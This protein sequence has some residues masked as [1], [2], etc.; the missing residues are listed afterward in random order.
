MK[1]KKL[2]VSN[3]L[4]LKTLSLE[5]PEQGVFVITGPNGSGKSSILEAMYFAL[6]GKTMRLPGDV[7]NTAIINR[8]AQHSSDR[9]ATAVVSFTF[10]QQG[11]E[12]L[13]RREL[14]R[15]P[16]KKD[17]VTHNAWFY[18]LNSEAGGVPETG[19][20]KVNKKVEDILGLTPEV[21]AATVFLGQGKITELVEA[22]P[23]KRRKI[24][25]SILETHHLSKMQELVR[26]DL[27]ELQTKVADQVERKEI[28]E[29]GPFPEDLEKE[30][31]GVEENM[32][33]IIEKVQVFEQAAREL[34]EL[35]RT[36]ADMEKTE[37]DI[38]ALREEMGKLE[39]K[40]ERDAKIRLAK[41]L[42]SKYAE[43]E[44][45]QAQLEQLAQ[46][47]D[48]LKREAADW[49]DK[50]KQ[51]AGKVKQIEEQLSNL[52]D[53]APL[54]KEIET[55][56]QRLDNLRGLEVSLQE[57]WNT[58]VQCRLASEEIVQLT[59]EKR[60]L[61][62]EVGKLERFLD[63]IASSETLIEEYFRT[64]QNLERV[65]QQKQEAH[66]DVLAA[67]ESLKALKER[68]F[69]LSKDYSNL[70]QDFLVSRLTEYLHIGDTCP[71]CGSEITQLKESTLPEDALI[72]F[73]KL[74]MERYHLEQQQ[75]TAKE[76]NAELEKEECELRAA[77]SACETRLYPKVLEKMEGM[78]SFDAFQTWT[79]A[80]REA[81]LERSQRLVQLQ[82]E[83]HIK[84]DRLK[85]TYCIILKRLCTNEEIRKALKHSDVEE[86]LA[87]VKQQ[88]AEMENRKK[89]LEDMIKQ[90]KQER[91]DLNVSLAKAH[92]E[93]EKAKEREVELK[94][95]LG[96]TY[97]IK[98]ELSGQMD[99]LLSQLR[100]ELATANLSYEDY[101]LYKSEQESGA[102]DELRTL[103]GSLSLLER[104]L[105]EQQKKYLSLLE[106]RAVPSDDVLPQLRQAKEE[107][108][109]LLGERGR[110]Q[111]S[112]ELALEKQAELKQVEAQ[113]AVLEKELS[114]LSR[115]SDDLKADHF[116]DFY[117][118]E[119]MNE[120]VSSASSLLWEMS[121]GQFNLTF[122]SDSF[123]FDVVFDDGLVSDISN[124]SGGER[125]LVALSLAFAISQHFAGSLES[126]FLDEGLAW[127]DKENNTKLAQYLQNM[128]DGSILVGIVTHSE[129]FAVNFQRRLYVNGGKAQWI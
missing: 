9:P 13:V 63:V 11:K 60:K 99:R 68:T 27:R 88:I 40:A 77:L 19:V 129:E 35:Q 83:L 116:P 51:F 50:V 104:R 65:S 78:S 64:K 8:N 123:R 41:E 61:Q 81:F 28:L 102:A 4:G 73:G 90:I 22:K 3:F 24:F 79:R 58:L 39:E 92:V 52:E 26:G 128:E 108:E 72:E 114:V 57:A 110:I 38:K 96:E 89:N 122:D 55:L 16:H 101:L 93:L 15:N 113:L 69:L 48:K 7:K 6:Y 20:V 49:S 2:E 82:Q 12:Y 120:I 36:K 75:R 119:M 33:Q 43:L 124:L 70:E 62:S 29:Q 80:Q 47:E 76:R 14:E 109:L 87:Q 37:A 121:G 103:R 59:F 10:M 5:F 118:G 34:E 66:R 42:R 125:V 126:I 111:A 117:R 85:S 46:N 107:Y 71:V 1:P 21:F 91:Q 95:N 23:D 86:Q 67:E 17:E 112:M 53:E 127:L 44:K 74:E 45:W 54:E 100:E 18:D 97:R 106:N 84:R 105:E 25:D 98:E 32:K 31:Q 94:N 30:L 115:L 56:A